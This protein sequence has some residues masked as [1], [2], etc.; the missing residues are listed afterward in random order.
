MCFPL[1]R[2][3]DMIFPSINRQPSYRVEIPSMN[4]GI[5]THDAITAI[6]DNQMISGENV[7]FDKGY[8]STRPG[9]TIKL[10]LG[11]GDPGFPDE[12]PNVPEVMPN[13]AFD[14]NKGKTEITSTP[15]VDFVGA[16]GK[17]YV[18]VNSI[19][20]ETDKEF[21][22]FT[23]L[24]SKDKEN[25]IALDGGNVKL[26]NSKRTPY[27]IQD[28]NDIYAFS[29]SGIYK[30][31]YNDEEIIYEWKKLDESNYED[32]LGIPF[33]RPTV[34]YNAYTL[35]D[36]KTDCGYESSLGEEINLLS[37][38][39]RMVYTMFNPDVATEDVTIGSNK[40][41]AH[42]MWYGLARP[43]KRGKNIYVNVSYT[44]NNGNTLGELHTVTYNGEEVSESAF[45][46]FDSL[47][48]GVSANGKSFYFIHKNGGEFI[49]GDIINDADKTKIYK[50]TLNQNLEILATFN[51]KTYHKGDEIES[52]ELIYSM[53]FGEWYGSGSEGISGGSRLFLG[54]SALNK[55]MI[56][57]SAANNPLY[58]P[59]NNYINVG[60]TTTAVTGFG[61]QSNMLVIFKER[62]TYYTY[63]ADGMSY[64]AEDAETGRIQGTEVNAAT[65]PIIQIHSEIGCDLPN[66]IALCSNKLCWMNKDGKV[67]TLTDSNQY[68]TSNIWEIGTNVE[69]LLKA[70]SKE[71]MNRAFATSQGEYYYLSIGNKMYLLDIMSYSFARIANYSYSKNTEQYL[72]WY[73]WNLYDRP[74]A[75]VPHSIDLICSKSHIREDGILLYKLYIRNFVDDELE[76]EVIGDLVANEEPNITKSPITSRIETKIFNFGSEEKF[77][78]IESVALGVGIQEKTLVNLEYVTD[79]GVSAKKE[80][81]FTGNSG[82]YKPD[83]IQEVILYPRLNRVKR[84]GMKIYTNG[85]IAIDNLVIKYKTTGGVR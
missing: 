48:L 27:I 78:N 12:R 1:R 31:K 69:R 33:Y 73:V 7:Y 79:R 23:Y 46:D 25:F 14:L 38:K 17:Y 35:A 2:I 5:N 62:E 36:S 26:P 65:F 53:S 47:K 3:K 85:K 39:Y 4:G 29:D 16:D 61:K 57:Y 20:N 50:N 60:D 83:F 75:F 68:S 45:S 6:G 22:N 70:H 58:F 59:E 18:V 67:Y 11:Y 8:L 13:T 80:L 72:V 40:Y 64:T 74:M 76:D 52:S 41:K 37:S 43:L 66:T 34:T 21:H 44:D 84:F 51:N 55:S 63:Q 56:R 9:T 19:Y 54:G 42:K 32:S 10:S 30:F 28:D 15:T 49:T 71:D 81:H 82:P 77:K 24:L